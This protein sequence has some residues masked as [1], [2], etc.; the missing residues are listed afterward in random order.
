[1]SPFP[2]EVRR[3]CYVKVLHEVPRGITPQLVGS[4]VDQRSYAVAGVAL[5]RCSVARE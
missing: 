1:M 4:Q 2:R 5:S 3:A